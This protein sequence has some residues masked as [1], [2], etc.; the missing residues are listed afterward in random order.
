M[1]R[2]ARITSS[3]NSN[4][5][6]ITGL[7]NNQSGMLRHGKM[8]QFFSNQFW[9]VKL[10]KKKYVP[11]VYDLALHRVIVKDTLHLGI[12]WF[13]SVHVQ[14]H[15]ISSVMFS[16]HKVQ[17]P[18]P[19]IEEVI[20]SNAFSILLASQYIPSSKTSSSKVE[21]TVSAIMTS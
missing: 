17:P 5:D 10:K 4:W 2:P 9:Q 20:T 6:V 18:R 16:L 3:T 12:K 11:R 7:H 8:K 13:S 19:Y 21:N 1:L 15:N 14:S